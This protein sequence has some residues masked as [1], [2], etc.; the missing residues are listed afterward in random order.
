MQRLTRLAVLTGM[1]VAVWGGVASADSYAPRQ[2]YSD[3]K[4]PTTGN[5]YLRK[6]YC[7]PTPTYAGYQVHEVRY[8][9][10]KPDHYYYYN[11]KTNKYWGRCP[12][13]CEGKPLYSLLEEEDRHGDLNKIQEQDFPPPGKLPPIPGSDPKEG[14]ALDLPPEDAPPIGAGPGAGPAPAP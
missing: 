8:F 6:Y 14:A 4:K 12:T 9:P 5:Y 1:L 7:K 2:Y 10:A 3:W 13:H 11:P